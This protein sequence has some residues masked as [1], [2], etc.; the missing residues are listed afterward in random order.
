MIHVS[1]VVAEISEKFMRRMRLNLCLSVVEKLL[2][3]LWRLVSQVREAFPKRV[4][5]KMYLGARMIQ[6][7]RGWQSTWVCTTW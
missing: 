2:L 6:E 1:C 7:F 4:L 5:V 3:E